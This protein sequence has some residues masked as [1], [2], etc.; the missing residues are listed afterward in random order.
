MSFV[1]DILMG[2]LGAAALFGTMLLSQGLC[3][4]MDLSLAD[5]SL[6]IA[7]LLFFAYLAGAF[8][9]ERA[10]LGQRYCAVRIVGPD[11]APAGLG[12]RWL[13]LACVLPPLVLPNLP[14]LPPALQAWLMGV[15]F[16]L[17]VWIGLGA[18]GL[19][20][21][22]HETVSG[23]RVAALALDAAAHEELLAFRRKFRASMPTAVLAA[24]GLFALGVV[25]TMLA[26]YHG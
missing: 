2:L 11:G 22:P 14:A 26:G 3:S 13:R 5:I 20:E 8:D 6:G 21:G 12:R 19:F 25:V 15:G 23:T 9:R 7:G 24:L 1:V 10:T 16:L 4:G 18:L 17:M